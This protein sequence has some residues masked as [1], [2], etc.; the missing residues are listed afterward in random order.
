[1]GTKWERVKDERVTQACWLVLITRARP[2]VR[3]EVGL[4]R[5]THTSQKARSMRHPR[6]VLAARAPNR[7]ERSR[8]VAW[9]QR[10]HK[11]RSYRGLMGP[12]RT[13]CAA[14]RRRPEKGLGGAYMAVFAMCASRG[15]V[16]EALG[17]G[18]EDE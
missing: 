9:N 4:P 16:A 18:A 13:R 2:P 12:A 10:F 15:W 7:W 14:Q 3:S 6:L 8:N 17:G 1:M 11:L 5:H